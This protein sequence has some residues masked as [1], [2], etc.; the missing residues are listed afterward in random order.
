MPTKREVA[1]RCA[2]LMDRIQRRLEAEDRAARVNRRKP[3]QETTR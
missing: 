1:R 3:K 2:P